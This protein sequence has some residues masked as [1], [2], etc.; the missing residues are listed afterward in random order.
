VSTTTTT[1]NDIPEAAAAAVAEATR[2]WPESCLELAIAT[3]TPD[4]GA[5][6]PERDAAAGVACLVG[7]GGGSS[8][9][10]SPGT[11]RTSARTSPEATT[12]GQR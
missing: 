6:R 2:K 9:F 1:N 5:H 3:G 8:S 11:R 10:C 12:G 4:T 7:S